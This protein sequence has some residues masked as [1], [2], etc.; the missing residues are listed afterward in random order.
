MRDDT[1]PGIVLE[2][3]F[4]KMTRGIV[5]FGKEIMTIYPDCDSFH[6]DT[7][8]SDNSED[9]WDAIL[10]GKYDTH[11]L[12]DTGSNINVLPYGIYMKIEKGEAKPIANKIKILDHSKV[13]PMGILRDLLCQVGVT[14]I[15][16][17]FLILDIPV[18]KDVPIVVG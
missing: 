5:E 10:E 6:N 14:T 15:L 8:N 3:S 2:R 7:N 4:L 9:D 1:I 12:V 17:R 16:P 11:A 13:E 18:D